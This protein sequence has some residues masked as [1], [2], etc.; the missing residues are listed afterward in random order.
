MDASVM[1]IRIRKWIALLEEQAKSGMSKNDWCAV[2]GIERTS[3][4]RWQ[5]RVRSYLLEHRDETGWLQAPAVD[6]QLEQG[7]FVELPH[8]QMNKSAIAP[9]GHKQ[10]EMSQENHPLCV[11]YGGFSV[12]ISGAV[13]ER[14]LTTVLRAMRH[15]D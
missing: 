12:Q 2:N 6:K 11:F 8:S 14:Q 3:F 10:D 9:S 4:F 15:A 13:D 7:G 1:D 5:R